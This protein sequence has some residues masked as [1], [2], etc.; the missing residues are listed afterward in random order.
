MLENKQIALFIDVDNCELEHVHYENVLNELGEL[1]TVK[2][3][4]VYG[5]NERKHKKIIADAQRLGYRVEFTMT[6]KKRGKRVFDT[7]ILVDVA[8]LVA[9]N[10]SIDTVAIVAEPYN[11]VHLYSMLSRRGITILSCDNADE[12]SMSYVSDYIDTGKV[13]LL[14]LPEMPKAPAKTQPK[15]SAKKPMKKA[16]QPQETKSE[17]VELAN[18]IDQMCQNI[19]SASADEQSAPSIST[20]TQN[21]MDRIKQ[22][23]DELNC[24]SV[25]VECEPQT[26]VE[27]V[28]TAE[29][30]TETVVEEPLETPAE[31]MPTEETSNDELQADETPNEETQIEEQPIEET[32]VE[33]SNADETQ[34][35]EQPSTE[36]TTDEQQTEQPSAKPAPN[37]KTN[38]D[39]LAQIQRAKENKSNSSSDLNAQIQQLLSDL[40]KDAQR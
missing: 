13:E 23:T 8:E 6:D 5:V 17:A 36:P 10:P 26:Q 9:S 20:E 30:P 32:P 37:F 24:K 34:T 25:E 39:L 29:E 4:T 40:K 11:M 14:D 19:E 28:E 3:V 27:T 21:L 33:E 31:Q 1:G 38:D 35:D 16:E 2:C 7:R 18:Q 15:P 12:F 22:Y